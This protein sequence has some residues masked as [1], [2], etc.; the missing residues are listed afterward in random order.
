VLLDIAMETTGDIRNI[1]VE[2]IN[3]RFSKGIYLGIEVTIDMTNGY[4]NGPQLVRQVKNR[5]GQPRRFS[6]WYYNRGVK[7]LINFISQ[8]EGI[9]VCDLIIDICN[10]PNSVR[11]YYVH[12]F[13]V[14]HVA[15]WASPQLAHIIGRIMNAVACGD[16]VPTKLYT[17][18]LVSPKVGC[19]YFIT[20]GKYIK[21]GYTYNL[22]D[23][24]SSLQTS[25]VKELSV[26]RSIICLN[27]ESFEEQLHMKFTDKRVRGEWFKLTQDEI[28]SVEAE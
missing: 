23:R 8:N 3:D 13:L 9:N 16:S 6:H 4:I 27:P 5:N 21:I 2:K 17:D 12:P 24:L 7:T 11:G 14:P 20:D 25:N 15:A 26:V 22:P 1:A 18:P 10:V 19:V 28:N